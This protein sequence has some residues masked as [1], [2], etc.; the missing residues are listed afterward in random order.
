NSQ[1]HP[2]TIHWA[3]PDG[4]VGW[5]ALRQCSRVDA[6]A[7]ARRLR[8]ETIGDATFAIH[9]AGA[10]EDDCRG[11]RWSLPGLD[12]RVRTDATGWSVRREDDVIKIAYR[13]A[14]RFELEIDEGGTTHSKSEYD[15]LRTLP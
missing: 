14:T 11:D 10:K 8:I 4:S 15:L 2:A 3:H 1:F 13:D 9:A 5:L 6:F 12:V 7:E